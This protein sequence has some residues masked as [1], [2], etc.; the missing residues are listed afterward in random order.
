MV[1]R[2]LS[3]P[4]LQDNGSFHTALYVPALKLLAKRLTERAV[5]EAAYTLIH[6][7]PQ[8][9]NQSYQRGIIGQGLIALAP[10]LFVSKRDA[11]LAAILLELAKEPA[12]STKHEIALA[13]DGVAPDNDLRSRKE[14]AEVILSALP[15]H[16]S[17]VEATTL[18]RRLS[19]SFPQKTRT[20][21]DFHLK[22]SIDSRNWSFMMANKS[23]SSHWAAKKNRRT[24]TVGSVTRM[25]Q[26]IGFTPTGPTLN[27]VP[28][29]RRTQPK[30]VPF[31]NLTLIL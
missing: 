27:S 25:L 9:Q 1:Y 4:R 14:A 28:I 31:V 23:F 3:I 10:R 18:L 24:K 12:V 16:Y 29:N 13:I 2:V 8:R 26:E 11:M 19:S 7:S 20:R 15:E 17:I 5:G 6:Q 21:L 22:C 30:Q